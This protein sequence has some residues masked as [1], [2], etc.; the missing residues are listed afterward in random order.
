MSYRAS[1]F[2]GIIVLILL[3]GC[4]GPKEEQ[5]TERP[6]EEVDP[7]GQTVTFWYQ[8]TRDREEELQKLIAEFNETNPQKIKVVGEYAGRYED[9]YKKMVVGIQSGQ[10]PGLIVAYQNQA[11]GYALADAIVDLNPYMGSPK[12]GLS[13][14]EKADF[15][16][17]FLRQ[18]VSEQLGIRLGFPP[19]RSMEVLYYNEDWLKELGYDGPPQNWMKFRE[20]ACKAA[21]QPFSKAANPKNSLGY[22]L[23][24]DASRFA[25]MVFSRGGD[26]V[27]EELSAYT[28]NTPQVRETL[29]FVRD[30]IDDG[31]ASIVAER[32]DDQS[33][34]AAGSLLFTIGSSSGLPFYAQ[35]VEQGV[36]FRWSVSPLPHSTSEPVQNIYGASVSVPRTTPER[37]LAAWLF[38]KW[39]TEPAQQAR[40]VRAS[41][42]FPVR[43]STAANLDE[44]FAANPNYR[45]A[46]D[47][48]QYGRSEPSVSG[49][50]RVRDMIQRTT[51][52]VA[53]GADVEEALV[54]LERQAN[55]NLAENRVR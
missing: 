51:V 43:R 19:N 6:L 7:S 31:C 1:F 55:E 48:L 2:W 27:N 13:E 38:I 39:M 50:D 11:L 10:L 41:N 8:H 14:E 24:I 53:K 35:G 34:F 17:A 54:D 3:I 21:K 15:F 45:K 29:L 44:Y 22:Q 5:R 20:M 46:F 25:S 42:Y 16:P 30:L 4:S 12:W 23:S 37:Q 9:I 32:Y 26:L 47:L 33:D 18:D 49:Y 36:G 52:A 40:W 28:L